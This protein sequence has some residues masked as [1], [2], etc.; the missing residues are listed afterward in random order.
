MKNILNT[1]GVSAGIAFIIYPMIAAAYMMTR[2]FQEKYG[3]I[4][5]GTISLVETKDGVNITF[6]HEFFFSMLI[7]LVLAFLIFFPIIMMIETKKKKKDL[8]GK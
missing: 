5:F 2:L 1:L 6:T 3:D 8:S 7:V 4:L